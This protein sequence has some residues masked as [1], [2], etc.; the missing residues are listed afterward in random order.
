MSRIRIAP[1][2]LRSRRALVTSLRCSS[3]RMPRNTIC[4]GAT[5]IPYLL[6]LVNCWLV[7]CWLV[8]CWLVNCWLV[9]CWL[10]NCWLVQGGTGSLPLLYSHS[11]HGLSLFGFHWM[12]RMRCVHCGPDRTGEERGAI[13]SPA[14][15]CLFVCLCRA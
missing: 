10:V 11:L 12:P 2:L 4:K 14:S 3:P 6:G 1:R 8:N 7:N 9:N 13:A 5:A 15:V